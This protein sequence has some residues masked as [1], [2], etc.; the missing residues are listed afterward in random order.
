MT[1][2]CVHYRPISILPIFSKIIEK[3]LY[4]RMYSFLEKTKLLQNKQFVFR[5]N[6]STSYAS[7]TGIFVDTEIAFDNVNHSI[8]CDKLHYY[9]FRGKTNDLIGNNMFL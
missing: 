8:L 5:T 4:S 1:H 6:H 2:H 3:I 9:G 7:T